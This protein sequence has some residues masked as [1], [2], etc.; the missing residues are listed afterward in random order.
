[1]DSK[2][3]ISTEDK[4]AYKFFEGLQNLYES[5]APVVQKVSKGIRE[6]NITKA[7]DETEDLEDVPNIG[8]TL[9]NKFVEIY[10]QLKRKGIEV[11]APN[12]ED[13]KTVYVVA[14]ASIPFMHLTNLA[15]EVA[16]EQLANFIDRQEQ[17]E[18]EK[19]CNWNKIANCKNPIAKKLKTKLWATRMA[20]KE[21]TVYEMFYSDDEIEE[22][23]DYLEVYRDLD[24]YIN[25]YDIKKDIADSAVYFFE[26]GEYSMDE[27]EDVLKN[28]LEEDLKKMGMED[29]IQYIRSRIKEDY[30]DE[31]L[32]PWELTE[33][34]KRTI[35]AETESLA[36]NAQEEK[37]KSKEPL[38]EK[39]YTR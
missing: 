26:L 6:V 33:Q 29:Q 11:F 21:D 12:E 25:E 13:E 31:N 20:F 16:N 34:E 38:K 32:K 19:E 10:Q 4:I 36:R 8:I 39:Q 2:A 17:L 22:L 28:G 5:I 1:M 24:T 27:V 23:R 14:L 18:S 30:K 35:Q 15:S 7:Y 3:R 37:T 9:N